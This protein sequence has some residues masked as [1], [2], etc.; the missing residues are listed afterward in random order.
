LTTVNELRVSAEEAA[1]RGGRVIAERLNRERVV[2]F[3]KG[4]D[5]V[6]DA[7][8][9]SE[10]EILGYLRG[11]HPDHSILAEESGLSSL[12][13]GFRW[14]VDPLDGTANYARG[15]PHF[16]VS[17]A[18]EGPE[19]VL[20]GAV[21]EPLR[22]ELFSAAKGEGATLNGRAIRVSEV[23]TLEKAM[24]CTGFPYDVRLRPEPSV[25]LLNR[26]ITRAH[27]LL[28]M[29]A[30][31]LDLAY[32]ACGRY[33]GHFQLGVYPWDIAAG[34]LLVTEAGGVCSGLDGKPLDLAGGNVIGSNPRIAAELKA[35][36]AAVLAR[37]Y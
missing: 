6:T 5:P 26:L 29:G 18:V 9:A 17:V 15:V 4:I 35:E 13:S 19:G 1:R 22:D 21:Y 14:V 36:I 20:A 31:A 28:R 27:G 23:P 34:S 7:D 10:E 8:R 30:A 33:D 16:C 37:P 24:L 32:V 25:P 11:R 12:P 2:E 3:K